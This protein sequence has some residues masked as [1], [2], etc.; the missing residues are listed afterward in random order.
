MLLANIIK[1]CFLVDFPHI[2]HFGKTW[3]ECSK[4]FYHEI[5]F[6]FVLFAGWL[7]YDKGIGGGIKDNGQ[8]LTKNKVFWPTWWK[9]V[10]KNKTSPYHTINP[11]EKWS[12]RERK[13][14][15]FEGHFPRRQNARVVK[16]SSL[17]SKNDCVCISPKNTKLLCPVKKPF[18]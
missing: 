1:Q 5:Y 11:H 9:Q 6:L 16:L 13:T 15:K 2:E 4:D 17:I 18:S 14:F 12:C 7:S 3:Q 8:K 10:P